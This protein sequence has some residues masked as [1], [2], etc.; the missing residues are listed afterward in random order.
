MSEHKIKPVTIQDDKYRFDAFKNG[1]VL[2]GK[3]GRLPAMGWNSWN[4]F[5]SGN[6][7]EL[8]KAMEIK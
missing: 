4:A 2:F 8:T 3:K 5:G 7:E 1:E 6:N